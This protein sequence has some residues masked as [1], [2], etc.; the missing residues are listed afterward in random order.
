MK[1]IL[2]DILA[3]LCFIKSR[4]YKTGL[5]ENSETY[6]GIKSAVLMRSSLIDMSNITLMCRHPKSLA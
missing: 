3:L 4:G 2:N 5:C 6:T 1:E